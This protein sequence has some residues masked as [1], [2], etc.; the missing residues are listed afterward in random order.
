[1]NRSKLV[2][3]GALAVLGILVVSSILKGDP[4][5]NDDSRTG[6]ESDGTAT[7]GLNV[8]GDP[9]ATD[10]ASTD[11]AST[12]AEPKRGANPSTAVPNGDPPRAKR[13]SKPS[14]PAAQA[15]A[16]ARIPEAA[17]HALAAAK[18]EIDA[19]N[20]RAALPAIGAFYRK[21]EDR[22]VRDALRPKLLAWASRYLFA[23]SEDHGFYQRVVI[24]PG[25]SLVRI[26]RRIGAE[27]RIPIDP[28]FVQEVNRIRD[29]RRIRAGA[30][31]MVPTMA[32][33]IIVTLSEFRLDFYLGG[34]LA[35]SY[36]VGI[37][38]TDTPTPVASWVVS[39][40]L[41]EPDWFFDGKRIPFGDPRNELGERWIG[42]KHESLQGFGIHGTNDDPSI[43]KATSRGCVRLHNPQVVELY[44]RVPLGTPVEIR[45]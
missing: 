17:A 41:D 43:G 14:T 27:H 4:A 3:F 30:R 20:V 8:G 44:R 36:S 11:P 32:P 16:D 18:R 45:P 19:G 40:K 26:A 23:P 31:L 12:G 29:P 7:P 22:A 38:K 15:S 33:A 9:A 37:G 21:S 10:P 42:L 25:D 13:D 5:E 35:S 39:S 34:C 24:E 1:M 6:A 2:S 28:L